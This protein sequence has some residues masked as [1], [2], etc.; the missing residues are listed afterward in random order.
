MTFFCVTARGCFQSALGW[1]CRRGGHLAPSALLWA[2][3]L[4]GRIPGGVTEKDKGKFSY[5]RKFYVALFIWNS[6]KV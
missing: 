1:L 2:Q 5:W 6:V 3:K 4:L